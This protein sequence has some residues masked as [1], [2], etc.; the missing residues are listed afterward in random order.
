MRDSTRTRRNLLSLSA[1]LRSMCLRICTAFLTKQYIS[2]GIDGARP[3]TFKI[4]RILLPVTLLTCGT[5][6]ESRSWMPIF[7][8]VIPF[9]AILQMCSSTAAGLIFNHA[10]A[11]RRYGK[12]EEAIPLPL[13]Y[14]RPMAV[15]CVKKRRSYDH[16]S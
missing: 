1:L 9:L 4:R 7:D 13:P 11:R 8:G 6:K 12:D 3:L 14:T 10:G 2:S 15:W 5:P 16:L